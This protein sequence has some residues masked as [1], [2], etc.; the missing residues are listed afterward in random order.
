MSRNVPQLQGHNLEKVLVE[1][2]KTL[3]PKEKKQKMARLMVKF[4]FNLRGI[5]S[6][7]DEHIN[8]PLATG[9]LAFVNH[10]RT[11]VHVMHSHDLDSGSYSR[12]TI[13]R[14]MK[15]AHPELIRRWL[16]DQMDGKYVI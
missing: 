3:D 16:F 1:V 10:R 8:T 7:V 2:L 11:L 13:P 5:Q 15:N 12:L 9:W 14:N 4:D 6:K